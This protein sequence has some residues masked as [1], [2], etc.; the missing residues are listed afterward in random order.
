MI[1]YKAS[2]LHIKQSG[3]GHIGNESGVTLTFAVSELG[4]LAFD[5]ESGKS[6]DTLLPNLSHAE[7]LPTISIANHIRS[8][9]STS[10][11]GDF[12]FPVLRH[13]YLNRTLR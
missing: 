2:A 8:V 12:Y 6:L 3:E 4:S 9:M 13:D 1:S 7:G 5:V 10:A 11:Q